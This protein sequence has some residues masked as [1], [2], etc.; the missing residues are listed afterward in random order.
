[1]S[2]TEAVL[3]ELFGSDCPNWAFIGNILLEEEEPYLSAWAL[4]RLVWTESHDPELFDV[5]ICELV[6]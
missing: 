3:D 1:M 6:D 5:T 2:N 4:M